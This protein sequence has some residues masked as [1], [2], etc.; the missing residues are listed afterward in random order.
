MERV[1]EVRDRARDVGAGCDR[2]GGRTAPWDRHRAF[3]FVAQAGV[4]RGDGGICAGATH[5]GCEAAGAAGTGRGFVADIVGAPAVREDGPGRD[6]R[7]GIAERSAV[8]DRWRGRRPGAA[9]PGDGR[10]IALQARL[11]RSAGLRAE[12]KAGQLLAVME[13]ATGT[14]GLGR[15]NLGAS[16]MRAPISNAPTLRDL[17]VS[18][19]QSSKWQKLADI[20]Q[21]QFE[22]GMARG[23]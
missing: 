4:G 10:Q 1:G 3:V 18:P 12:R 6:H 2:D 7:S 20:P 9:L 17:G 21:E 14:A 15:P 5:R 16:G 19:D 22:A 11:P 23:S 13:K 8:A